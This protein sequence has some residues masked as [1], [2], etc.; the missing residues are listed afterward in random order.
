MIEIDLDNLFQKKQHKIHD[1][2]HFGPIRQRPACLT[3]H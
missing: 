2:T 3:G 1:V